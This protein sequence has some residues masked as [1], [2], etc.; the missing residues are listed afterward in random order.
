MT[1]AAVRGRRRTA[2]TRAYFA[3]RCVFSAL[4]CTFLFACAF[5]ATSRHAVAQAISQ[6]RSAS[7]LHELVRGLTA[8]PRVLLIGAHPDDEDTNLI[9]WLSRGRSIETAYLSLTRGE[10]GR[11]LLG[12]DLGTSLGAVR[13]QEML[14]ARRVDGASQYFTRAFDFGFRSRRGDDPPAPSMSRSR[15]PAS[16]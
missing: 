3:G 14:A 8:T 4:A 7:R 2:A 10:S 11:N 1:T 9:V 16:S 15:R 5:L 13:V 6:D 12:D